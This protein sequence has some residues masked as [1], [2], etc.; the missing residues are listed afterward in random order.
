MQ[1]FRKLNQNWQ[2][3]GPSK[4]FIQAVRSC[5][6]GKFNIELLF[7][8]VKSIG[9]CLGYIKCSLCEIL[10]KYL[11]NSAF[12]AK[13]M[14][15]LTEVLLSQILIFWKLNSLEM[16]QSL[17][18]SILS[19]EILKVSAKVNFYLKIDSNFQNFLFLTFYYNLTK[20]V[21]TTFAK[22]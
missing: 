21:C 2:R 4:I 7:F 22:F 3:Y 18:F 19:Y 1:S 15:K 12:T 20:V 11:I 10:C 5:F 6:H 14:R 8:I 16:Y 13:T 17:I 9:G